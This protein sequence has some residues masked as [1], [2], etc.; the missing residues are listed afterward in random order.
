M[1]IR[2]LLL[3]WIIGVMNLFSGGDILLGQSKE[4]LT[5]IIENNAF[6][7]ETRQGKIFIGG[8]EVSEAKI[9]MLNIINVYQLFIS[10]QDRPTCN[11]TISCSEFGRVAT[12]RYGLFYGLLMTSDRIQRCNGLGR[13]YYRFDF[14]AGLCIDFPIEYYYWRK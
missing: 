3:L 7:S 6:V 8:E 5:F 14:Q 1:V 10:S 4:D 2:R 9:L 12:Q 13:R 11:F